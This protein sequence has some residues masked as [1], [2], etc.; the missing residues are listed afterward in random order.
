M[1]PF[2]RELVYQVI[3]DERRYQENLPADRS[4]GSIKSV[5]DYLGLIA[6]CTRRGQDTF[7]DTPGVKP[8]LH[9]VRKIAALAVRCLEE[10]GAP[11]R[12]T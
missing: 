12:G 7:Y 3:D 4:D 9:Q 1:R 8:A 6:T 10:H 11:R 5:G 2:Q